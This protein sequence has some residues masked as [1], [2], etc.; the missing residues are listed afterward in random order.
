MLMLMLTLCNSPEYIPE[1][2]SALLIGQRHKS[3]NRVVNEVQKGAFSANL[4]DTITPQ[5]NA[6]T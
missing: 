4:P 1:F 5:I 2:P 3:F 6:V